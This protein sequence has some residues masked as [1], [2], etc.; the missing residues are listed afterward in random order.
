MGQVVIKS[1]VIKRIGS[2]RIKM[3]PTW[4]AFKTWRI[5]RMIK[6]TAFYNRKI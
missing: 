6:V 2:E 3:S 5:F 1:R 4:Y